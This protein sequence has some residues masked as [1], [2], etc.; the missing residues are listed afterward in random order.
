MDGYVRCS[1]TFIHEVDVHDGLSTDTMLR[2]G[3][4]LPSSNR[5]PFNELLAEL[6]CKLTSYRGADWEEMMTGKMLTSTVIPAG[7]SDYEN[8]DADDWGWTLR[9]ADC[10]EPG[11][12]RRRAGNFP[13]SRWH[14]PPLIS[15]W[16]EHVSHVATATVIVTNWLAEYS[17]SAY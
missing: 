16:E 1:W 13:A 12:S 6:F 8:D 5:C 11:M 2:S 9:S 15:L 14:P 4:R 3:E 10:C 17:S 7:P